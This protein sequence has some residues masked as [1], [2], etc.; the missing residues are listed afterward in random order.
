MAFNFER[1][2]HDT[3][4]IDL[5]HKT[6]VINDSLILM[7]AHNTC[8]Y[9]NKIFMIHYKYVM[10]KYKERGFLKINKMSKMHVLNKVNAKVNLLLSFLG[11]RYMLIVIPMLGLFI[12][13]NLIS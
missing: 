5:D 6:A 12:I 4:D 2:Y 8:H 13:A 9:K 7:T 1:L 3:S 11:V 10:L